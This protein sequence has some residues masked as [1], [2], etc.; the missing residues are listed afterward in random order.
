MNQVQKD[1]KLE[2]RWLEDCAAKFGERFADPRMFE[3]RKSCREII[4]SKS[5][6]EDVMH[7]LQENKDK[8]IDVGNMLN[9]LEEITI[10]VNLGRC[11]EEMV[12]WRCCPYVAGSRKM[13][14][15]G[16]I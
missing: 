3:V 6:P 10:S 16:A 9:F 14:K 13:D 11:D 8:D 4:E 5:N 1:S 7:A 15:I 12:P 2:K